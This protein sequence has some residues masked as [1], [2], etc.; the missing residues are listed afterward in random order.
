MSKKSATNP[1]IYI[2][3]I[4]GGA[5]HGI[6]PSVILSRVEELAETPSAH[7]F[8]VLNGVSTGS[9]IAGGLS[10]RSDTDATRP[11]FISH[12]CVE[13]FCRYGPKFFPKITGRI[14]KYMT[15]SILNF[16]RDKA[17]PAHIERSLINAIRE[18]CR[19][20]S[21]A[22]KHSPN[23]VRDVIAI[24]KLATA[25]Y[26]SKRSRRNAAK[27]CEALM[28]RQDVPPHVREM[29]EDLNTMI[30]ARQP[31][32]TLTATFNAA[33][34]KGMDVVKNV[35]AH[36]YLFDPKIAENTLKSYLGD[37]RMSDSIK[38]LYIS[39]LDLENRRMVTFFSRKKDFFSNDPETPCETSAGNEK[40]WDAVMAS[41]ANPFAYPPHRT[42]SNVLC[43]DKAP[44][45]TPLPCVEDV[46]LHKPAEAKVKLVYVGTGRHKYNHENERYINYGVPGNLMDG[47]EIDDLAQYTGTTAQDILVKKLGEDGFIEI[48][49]FISAEKWAD[50]QRMPSHDPLDAT[51]DNVKK[52]LTVSMDYIREPET[53]K[54]LK[55]LALE[56]SENLY[57]LGQMSEEK[58][59]RVRARCG[60]PKG[61]SNDNDE[62]GNSDIART[63][64]QIIRNIFPKRFPF[65]NFGS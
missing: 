44:V 62:N 20:I 42:E 48:N 24:R 50:E 16:F 36:D 45:H 65:F 28:V 5:M 3:Y 61:P 47:R 8:Q 32:G 40:I 51:P 9:I 4:P 49:P 60:P 22:S 11:K 10:V 39:T 30:L 13:L 38:S 15:A 21:D 57:N 18:K 52:I 2:L 17:D 14:A 59:A 33:V 25:G 1:T 41:I 7:L 23:V 58:I 12:D 37:A 63:T 46:L 31:R 34:F 35:W 55:A 27:T 54:A 64:N 29:L 6:I 26:V 53:D 19:A 43:G 56:L